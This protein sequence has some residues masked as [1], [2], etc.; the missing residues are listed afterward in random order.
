MKK[1]FL[2]L[3]INAIALYVTIIVMEGHGIHAQS[4]NW[5]SILL[6]AFIFGLINTFLRPILT[7]I[8]CSLIFITLGLA[9]LLINTLLFYLTGVVATNFGVGF[10][11]DGFWPAFWGALIVS[12]VSFILSIFLKGNDKKKK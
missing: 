5:L 8:G 4:E 3:I 11:V 12:V 6:L 2:R 1:F 10:T 9:T 7:T